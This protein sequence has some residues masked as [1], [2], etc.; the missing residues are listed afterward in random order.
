M[1]PLISVIIPSGRPDIV[2]NT[3][4]SLENQDFASD[5]IELVIV[6]PTAPDTVHQVS[7]KV[8]LVSTET[9]HA[10]GKM[11]NLG[12][13]VAMGKFLAFIDDD[14]LAPADWLSA[15]LRVLET[16][17]STGAVGCRVV[18]V[19][20][21]FWVRC[22]DYS[23]FSAY[24]QFSNRKTALGSA[25]IM[26]KKEAFKIVGGFDEVLLA[27][28]DWDFSL[29]LFARGWTCRFEPGVEIKHQ[30]GCNSFA[31]IIKKAHL[32]GLRSRLVV[33]Q[34]HRDQM[35]LLARLSLVLCSPWLYWLLIL[36]Y[37][38]IVCTSQSLHFVRY[39]PKVLLYFPIL[40]VSRIV[41]H[42]G[43]LGGLAEKG[44]RDER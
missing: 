13:A 17:I 14:C 3:L 4:R 25:A 24:Q 44:M 34:R 2:Q 41:Y 21:G 39:D 36:P 35:S 27:S 31:T 8:I 42:C 18:G 23:L 40:L 43:V 32:Y 9:L 6:S 30:H 33:Q 5:M 29:K 12:A 28:E 20:G 11:R 19:P 15:S 26:V 1:R 22:A 16:S 38:L 37:S 10:P 7:P